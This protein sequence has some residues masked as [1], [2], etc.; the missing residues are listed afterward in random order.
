MHQCSLA[1]RSVIN[2]LFPQ[3]PVLG[4]FFSS[5]QKQIHF[6]FLKEDSLEQKYLLL[7]YK[8]FPFSIFIALVSSKLCP[9]DRKKYGNS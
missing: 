1:N 3:F 9:H 8:M 2:N 4:F 5:L 7:D 6:S